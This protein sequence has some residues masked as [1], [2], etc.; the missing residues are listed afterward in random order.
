MK[1]IM[2]AAVLA[3]SFATVSGASAD[4]FVTDPVVIDQAQSG[5]VLL[6]HG[7]WTGR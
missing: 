5:H 7:I 2:T 4:T 1:T 3:L 6:P